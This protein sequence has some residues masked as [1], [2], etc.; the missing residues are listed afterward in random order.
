MKVLVPVDGSENALRAAQYVLQMAKTHSLVEV[1][2]LAVACDYDA[3]YYGG[4][5]VEQDVLNQRCREQFA[6]KLNEAKKIFDEAGVTVNSELR[7]GDPG[8]EIIKYVNEN[9]IDKV[10]MGSRGL[11]AFSAMIL[12]SVAYK[13][14]HGVKVPVT[15]VK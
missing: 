4:G 12:G 14:L 7:T 1:S 9:G 3:V 2:L 11:S 10:V 8:R 15:I 5:I 6:E 13:V